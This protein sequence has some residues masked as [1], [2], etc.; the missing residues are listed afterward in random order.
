MQKILRTPGD[1]DMTANATSAD[2]KMDARDRSRILKILESNWQAEMRGYHTYEILAQRETDPA[3]RAAFHTLSYAEQHHAQ[4]WADRI[5]ALGGPNPVY[6]GPKTGEADT[7][8]NRA[9]GVRMAL[10]RLE[11]D[12]SRDIAKYAKQIKE[13]GDQPSIRI[14]EQA[15]VDEREHYR[16]LSGLIRNR[17]P[18]PHS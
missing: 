2:S 11:V 17:R 7:L 15:L 10:R 5:R 14:L 9:G 4:L 18:F 12:E 13:L 8:A 6:K 1:L 16:T 3:R